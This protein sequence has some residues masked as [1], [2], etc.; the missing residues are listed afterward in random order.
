M[1]FIETPLG[2]A[3]VIDPDIFHDPRG[4]FVRSFC[5]RE[6]EERGLKATV[7]QANFS[8]NH[9]RGT[10]RG[11]HFQY[12]PHAET[13]LVRCTQGAILDVIVDLRPESATYLQH[14]AVE[15]TA[16]NRR[17]LYV[18]E[19]FAHGYQVLLDG[20]EAAYQVGEF[21]TPSAEGG[22]PFNDARLKI[23]WPLPLADIS[24]KDRSWDPL[25]IVEPELHRRMTL[26]AGAAMR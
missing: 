3:F 23:D 8:F 15:L 25:A 1:T 5:R 17:A 13:K 6:F 16:D 26:P 12:P 24:D 10:I 2:G 4:F 21:Y 18:P 22:L 19:R 7:A 20:T 9:R 14:T 11:L